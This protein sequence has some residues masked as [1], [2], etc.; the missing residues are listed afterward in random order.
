MNFKTHRLCNFDPIPLIQ[1]F[2]AAFSTF[3][4]GYGAP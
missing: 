3:E 4:K 2:A 1:L